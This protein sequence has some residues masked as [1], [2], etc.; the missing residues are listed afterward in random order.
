VLW[1]L[2]TFPTAGAAGVAAHELVGLDGA[3][4]ALAAAGV[5][6]VQAGALWRI[7]PGALQLIALHGAA[8]AVLVSTLSLAER[9][10]VDLFGLAVWA[11]GVA[12]G[13]LVW[14]GLAR[15]ERAGLVLAGGTVL[16]GGQMLAVG[17]QTPGLLLGLA[18]AAGLLAVSRP[19]GE[20][21]L[22][23][24]GVL[25]LAVF[26]PQLLGHWFPDSIGP[27]AALFVGGVVL[28]AGALATIR[29]GRGDAA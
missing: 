10:P 22:A 3:P 20:P 17:Y 11:A 13:L 4:V 26:T 8:L 5:T 15:P 9:P 6:A 12:L 28:L 21:L 24:G 16:V 1:L 29:S 7:R 27:P 18:T 19:L 14:G 25:G 23:G 2:A